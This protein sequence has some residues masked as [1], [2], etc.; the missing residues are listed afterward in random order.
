MSNIYQ[1][2]FIYLSSFGQFIDWS[3]FSDSWRCF[4]LNDKCS[5]IRNIDIWHHLKREKNDGNIIKYEI[6]IKERNIHYTILSG[7]MTEVNWSISDII[8]ICNMWSF[9]MMSKHYPS[10]D[11]ICFLNVISYHNLN[12][13]QQNYTDGFIQSIN[14]SIQDT[15]FSTEYEKPLSEIQYE[16]LHIIQSCYPI[17]SRLR[18]IIHTDLACTFQ[19][20]T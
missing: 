1:M 9:R 4:F 18:F 8:Y 20:F 12:T 17:S 19:Q 3:S 6:L 7:L 14:Q 11:E 10:T 15:Y 13:K 5:F 16:L 2:R